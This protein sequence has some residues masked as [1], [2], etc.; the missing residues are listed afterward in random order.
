MNFLWFTFQ[1]SNIEKSIRFY[2]DVVGLEVQRHIEP[3]PTMEIVFLGDE[4]CT[5]VELIY[6]MESKAK[7]E[8]PETMSIGFAVDD[9]KEKMA[10]VSHKGYAVHS[11]PIKPNPNTEFFYVLDPDGMKVQFVKE[12]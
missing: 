8:Y 1:V 5:K 10:E 12:G 2:K 11:G 6:N 3:S 9:I 4:N 7:L